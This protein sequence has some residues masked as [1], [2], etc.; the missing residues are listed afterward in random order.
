MRLWTAE[1]T[2][3]KQQRMLMVGRVWRV[4]VRAV[5]MEFGSRTSTLM[6][7]MVALGKEVRRSDIAASEAGEVGFTSQRARP[8]R[9]CS[10]RARAEARARVPVPPVTGV[11]V[12]RQSTCKSLEKW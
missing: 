6:A 12:N 8:E 1:T 11:F 9:P 7:I 2:P 4:E 5:E 3:A 10:R